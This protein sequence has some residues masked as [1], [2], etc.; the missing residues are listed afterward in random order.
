M[1]RIFKEL[2]DKSMCHKNLLTLKDQKLYL[3][4]FEFISGEFGQIFRKTFYAK[5]EE[6][7]EEE[8]HKY[9]MDYY[10]IG[11]TSEIDR[12]IYYYWNGE[13]AVKKHGWEEIASF[14]QLVNKLI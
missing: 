2:L 5:D 10:G 12:N 8:I 6:D 3:T 1:H 14:E 13:V 7:L 4:T 11:N 9:L